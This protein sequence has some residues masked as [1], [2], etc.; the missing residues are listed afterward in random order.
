M[1]LALPYMVFAQDRHG[2][3]IMEKKPHRKSE[4]SR[5]ADR[6]VQQRTFW[7][8]LLL[9]IVVFAAVLVKLYTLQIVQHEEL[10]ER[11][12][13]QQTRSTELTASRGVIYD[14]NGNI[15]A[16]SA[17]AETIFVSPLELLNYYK[18]KF[19]DAETY[20]EGYQP[21]YQEGKKILA[22]GLAEI[23]ELDEEKVCARLEKTN[24]QYEVLRRQVDEEL[25]DRVREFL[26]EKEI[27]GV[28]IVADSKRYY[29]YGAL[30]S[31]VIGFVGT[32]GYGLYGLEA[33]QNE[34]LEGTSGLVISAK[35]GDGTDLLYQYEQV[36]DAED[37]DSI[38][39]TIDTNIQYYLE[40]GLQSLEEK[41]GTGNGAAGIV[42]NPK[43]GA[44]LAMAS[45]PNY[46]LNNPREIYDENLKKQLEGLKD[47]EYSQKLGEL[48]L[49]Q[50]RNK[51]VNDTFEPGSTFKIVTLS[52][53]LEEHT[54][55]LNSEFNCNGHITV[56]GYPAVIN[57]TSRSGHGAQSLKVATGNSCNPAFVRI[58]LSIGT[59]TFYQYLKDYGLLNR[60]GIELNGE[61][62]GIAATLSN[63]TN[64]DLACYAFGQNINVT[65]VA[66]I[67]AQAA[68][69][70]GGYLHTPY[71]VEQVLDSEGNVK[72][73][74]DTTPVR[75]VISEETSETVRGI[76]EYVVSDGTG[77]N[78]QVAGYRIGGKTGTADKGRTGDV[79]VSFLCFAPADDPQVIMLLTLDTPS[80]T[81]GTFV[82]GGQMVAPTAST[83]MAEILPYLG[84]ESEVTESADTTV[85]NVIGMSPEEA[86][87]KLKTKELSYRIV[88]KG[89]TV[90]DQTP[91][92]GAIIP[93]NSQVVLYCGEKKSDALCKVPNVLE[94]TATKAN[95]ALTDAG[96]I[97]KV[98]GATAGSTVYA[99]SQSVEAGKEVPAGTVVT[100]QFGDTSLKD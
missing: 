57:C 89:D 9:G 1:L 6:I 29:P 47:E 2:V 58:G 98:T 46:D 92:G 35:S 16:I 36:Y 33:T 65:P 77:K 7:F 96:L 18:D 50:W 21:H 73:Q 19:E 17:T 83:V 94:M 69:I 56:P 91:V 76:L 10:E 97:M 70:N 62:S 41:F 3:S 34:R 14:K 12:V 22:A 63:F 66:L 80:R 8:M 30:A 100:V 55:T 44:I 64:L 86:K 24:S 81:T 82:S 23:L 45:Y 38:V 88:G 25:A 60:T 93:V 54:V 90:T 37:G 95:K 27:K 15:L 28:Y 74:H 43:T 20:P 71:L 13:R 78:G 52:T 40:Q 32:D 79:I 85:P 42:M 53:A 5:R 11:A 31:H 67:S 4:S 87:S 49:L 72:A 61:T 51:T 39:T 26:N 68:A 84:I 99:I 75:Q 59:D 48:Q